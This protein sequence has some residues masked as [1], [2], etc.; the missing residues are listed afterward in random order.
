MIN[1]WYIWHSVCFAIFALSRNIHT[2]KVIRWKINII[3]V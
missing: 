1:F 3:T 2:Q